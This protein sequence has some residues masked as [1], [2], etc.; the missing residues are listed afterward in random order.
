MAIDLGI[1]NL[2][3][4]TLKDNPKGYIIDGKVIKLEN[5]YYN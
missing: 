1:D 5:R 4:I 3:T 2:A